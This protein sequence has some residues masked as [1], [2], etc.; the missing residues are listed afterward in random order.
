MIP[1]HS[2]H[3]S[4]NVVNI[5][6]MPDDKFE[7]RTNSLQ[8]HGLMDQP[9][10]PP[11]KTGGVHIHSYYNGSTAP[12]GGAITPHS[13]H[14]LE[15][16]QYQQQQLLSA[17]EGG[18]AGS[19]SSVLNSTSLVNSGSSISGSGSGGSG[20]GDS[21]PMWTA[22]NFFSSMAAVGVGSFKKGE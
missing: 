6:N 11:P 20:G 3:G 10:S 7:H 12:R 17:A 9:L 1:N 5:V 19:A 16:L 21:N 14:K 13:L 15:Q 22:F 2:R 4:Q 18:Y 8:H